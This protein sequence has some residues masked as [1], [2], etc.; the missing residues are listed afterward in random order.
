MEVHCALMSWI[1]LKYEPHNATA[2]QFAG[3]LRDR[4]ELGERL[5]HLP[6]WS[7]RSLM[8]DTDNESSS[9]E[10]SDED[11]DV[12]GGDDDGASESSDGEASS[13]SDSK[14]DSAGSDDG[15]RRSAAATNQPLDP[16][17][18][19]SDA[20]GDDTASDSEDVKPMKLEVPAGYKPSGVVQRALAGETG[21]GL[22][23]MVTG[24]KAYPS[25]PSSR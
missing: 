1:V 5:D 2:K 18:A 6:L 24:N 13:G 22:G 12:G 20:V 25:P 17:I 7:S 3:V 14:V 15:H 9:E 4:L 11:E 19:Q 23:L 21:G 16:G 10:S 8:V